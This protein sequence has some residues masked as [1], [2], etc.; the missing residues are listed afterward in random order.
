M[1]IDEKD[2]GRSAT[3]LRIDTTADGICR[4]NLDA[5]DTLK[6]GLLMLTP[7]LLLV[8]S[9]LPS[10]P[11]PELI[12]TCRKL[13][14]YDGDWLF[15]ISPNSKQLVGLQLNNHNAPLSQ[16]RTLVEE[17]LEAFSDLTLI[18]IEPSLGFIQRSGQ[19]IPL[20]AQTTIV[21]YRCAPG[22][23]GEV[24]DLCKDLFEYAEKEEMDVYSLAILNKVEDEDEF[25]I[26]ERYVDAAAEKR[27]LESEKCVECLGK[28]KDMIVGHVS[29]SYEILDV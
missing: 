26:L 18:P 1:L 20:S 19:T 29:Q 25:V 27:H 10:I 22:K 12:S 8:S 4:R 6:L 13:T 21:S 16:T 9:P 24:S 5:R 11:T 28:I 14:Q 7:P 3:A 17:T 15:L 23:R 2:R